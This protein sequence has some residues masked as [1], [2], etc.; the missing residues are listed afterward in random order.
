MGGAFACWELRRRPTAPSGSTLAR[1]LASFAGLALILAALIGYDSRMPFPGWWALVPTLGSLVLIAAGP[2]AAVNRHVLARRPLVFLGLLSYPL[3]VWHWPLLS[4]ARIVDPAPSLATRVA[5]V[6]LAF[7][8]A[9]LTFQFVER[10]TRSLAPR[11]GAVLPLALTL[12]VVGAL[13]FLSYHGQIR[14]YSARFDLGKIM[15]AAH[16][17]S[18]PGPHLRSLDE[19]DS[20]LREQGVNSATAL[21]LG[22]SFVEQYYPRVDWLLETHASDLVSVVFATS[23][24]CPPIPA[25]EEAHHQYC[26]G[27]LGRAE[28]FAQ[29]SNVTRVVI[30]ANWLGYFV[31]PDPR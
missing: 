24:G 18:F 12:A 19:S 2:Q 14:P 8:L 30:G 4:L 1:H 3:Y 7:G 16:S 31:Q 6:L 17:S 11:L 15:Q 20:P 26:K 9:W 10:P 23:G 29:H 5:L 21:F 28:R 27:L 22:D 13:G 25:V